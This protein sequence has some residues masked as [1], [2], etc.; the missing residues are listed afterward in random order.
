LRSEKL[1]RETKKRLLKLLEILRS[2]EK[3]NGE[4]PE[5]GCAVAHFYLTLFGCLLFLS[6]SESLTGRGGWAAVIASRAERCYYDLKSF[7]GLERPSFLNVFTILPRTPPSMEG[8][9]TSP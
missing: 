6:C 1:E 5:P 7:D 4:K 8:K 9:E 3:L 2:V